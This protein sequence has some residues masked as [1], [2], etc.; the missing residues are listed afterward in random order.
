MRRGHKASGCPPAQQAKSSYAQIS[1]QAPAKQEK[2]LIDQV[3]NKVM[4]SIQS[5]LEQIV[6]TFNEAFKNI[7]NRVPQ[8]INNPQ[9][10][11]QLINTV[12]HNL[13]N[14]LPSLAKTITGNT[15][16][17]TQCNNASSSAPK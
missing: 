8:L 2:K 13:A 4:L 11:T 6:N 7:L 14:S 15:K 16:T 1:A 9:Q 12:Q 3:A 10:S 17:N 5:Y